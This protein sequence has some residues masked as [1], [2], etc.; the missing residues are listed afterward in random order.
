MANY[1]STNDHGFEIRPTTAIHEGV[2]KPRGSPRICGGTSRDRDY[3]R[4]ITRDNGVGD[5]D[6]YG[7][8]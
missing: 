3:P 6:G 5:H 4:A 8:K 2:N 7:G 1:Q